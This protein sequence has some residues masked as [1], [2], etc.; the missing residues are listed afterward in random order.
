[1]SSEGFNLSSDNSVENL[2]EVIEEINNGKK[3]QFSWSRDKKEGIA[4]HYAVV[5]MIDKKPK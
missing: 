1:M 2:D 4:K 3:I 5:L